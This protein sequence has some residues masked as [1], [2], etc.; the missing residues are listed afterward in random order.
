MQTGNISIIIY[1]QVKALTNIIL[2]FMYMESMDI[3]VGIIGGMGPK[4]TNQFLDRLTDLTEAEK[5][6]DHVRYIL[7]NDPE[8]P[9][10]IDAYFHD[11]ASP[12]N[13]INA[14]IEFMEKNGIE[15]VGIPCNTVHIW[16]D[17]FHSRINVLNMID[18]TLAAILESGYEKPGILATNAT[19]ESG[20]YI[21]DLRKAG[22]DPVIPENEDNVM[23]AVQEVKLGN[24]SRGKSLLLPVVRELEN[25][26]VDS[27]IMACTEIP[28]ILDSND[29]LL[30]LIDSD[31]LLAEKLITAAG[32]KV[33]SS[34]KTGKFF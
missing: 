5:D 20:L 6:Q 16:F 1:F 25:A 18:L 13:A 14:G 31:R 34:G 28:V 23:K 10:R 15:T 17:Q 4:A 19:I 32:K 29:T 33:K 7:Y 3:K 27:L 21:R 12:V 8:I 30:P 9:N 22:I 11:G 2:Y 26:G 24:I